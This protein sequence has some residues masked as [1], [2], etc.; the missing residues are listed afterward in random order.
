MVW[1]ATSILSVVMMPAIG[2][3]RETSPVVLAAGIAGSAVFFLAQALAV[4]TAVTPWVSVRIR[5]GVLIGFVAAALA[6]VPL[7]VPVAAGSWPTWAWLGAALIGTTPLLWRLLPAAA[8][9]ACT[10]AVSGVAAVLTST[11]VGEHVLIT[12]GLGASIAAVNWAPVWLWELLV[13]AERGRVAQG[14]LAAIEERLR[15][16]RDVHDLLGHDLT[17]I[18]LRAELAARVAATD[19]ARAE[20]EAAAARQL[21]ETALGRVRAAVAGY[22]AVDLP[23]EIEAVADLLQASGV[24]CATDLGDGTIPVPQGVADQLSVV[25]REATTNVLRHS[26][27]TWCQIRL[28]T[29]DSDTVLTVANDGAN[30]AGPDANSFGLRGLADRLAERG[31]SFHIHDHGGVFTLTA[32][33][34]TGQE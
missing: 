15:F 20:I 11:S 18:A 31:G 6:S 22:R 9:S 12:G 4:W 2:L 24:K 25:L 29:G 30:G 21:A 19:P 1:L 13:Q 14:R 16:A 33:V 7:V 5:R 8:V 27:A 17:V 34:P 23:G 10:V 3:L 32:T 26:R 28:A